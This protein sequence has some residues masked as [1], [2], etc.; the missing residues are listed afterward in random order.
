MGFEKNRI[1]IFCSPAS[2]AGYRTFR[3]IPLAHMDALGAHAGLA[4]VLPYRTAYRQVVSVHILIS[5]PSAEDDM[6][7]IGEPFRMVIKVVIDDSVHLREYQPLAGLVPLEYIHNSSQ[8]C[9][10]LQ[11]APYEKTEV[12]AESDFFLNLAHKLDRVGL[13]DCAI[14]GSLHLRLFRVA[15]IAD[16]IATLGA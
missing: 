14:V 7:I 2:A 3:A 1:S 16:I 5:A 6:Q 15:D 4:P 13:I 9:R 8:H 10:L 11:V 12:A